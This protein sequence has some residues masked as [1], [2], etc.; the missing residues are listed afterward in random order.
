MNDDVSH[1]VYTLI[2]MISVI[3]CRV[4]KANIHNQCTDFN[5]TDRHWSVINI[6]WNNEPDEE[7]DAGSMASAELEPFRV[8]FRGGLTYRLQR[9]NIQ[10]DD[11]LESTSTL[12]LITW[13]SEG[14]KVPRVL[15]CLVEYDKQFR[16]SGYKLKEYHQRYTNQLSTY[17]GP[18]EDTWLIPDSTVLMTRLELDFTQ[19]VGVL[20]ITITEGVEGEHTKRPIWINPKR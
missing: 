17:T 1:Y 9:K 20:N 19:R 14:Y 16:W 8:K 12:L 10:S 4:T 11:Q 2:H 15:V 6:Y 3:S 5:L 13:K 18:V 7:I